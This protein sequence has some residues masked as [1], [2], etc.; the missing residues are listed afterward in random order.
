MVVLHFKEDITKIL[1]GRSHINMASPY[2]KFRFDYL[3]NSNGLL[4]PPQ[5][6]LEPFQVFLSISVA[7]LKLTMQMPSKS[8]FKFVG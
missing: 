6:E 4:E 2:N 1:Q 5:E 8:N 3:V 7:H